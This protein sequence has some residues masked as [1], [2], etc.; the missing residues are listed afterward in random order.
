MCRGLG[1]VVF[2]MRLIGVEMGTWIDGE[3][4]C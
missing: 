2:M 3:S 4:C 1:K